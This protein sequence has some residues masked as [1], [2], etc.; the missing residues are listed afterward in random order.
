MKGRKVLFLFLA[1]SSYAHAYVPEVSMKI[2]ERQISLSEQ[3][4][5]QLINEGKNLYSKAIDIILSDHYWG[6]YGEFTGVA[7]ET[8]G[9]LAYGMALK[10]SSDLD[11][12]FVYKYNGG[13]SQKNINAF[14]L[15]QEALEAIKSVFGTRYTY[16]MKQPVINIK[17]K[18][19]DIDIAFF[20]E[21]KNSTALCSTTKR[22]SEMNVGVDNTTATWNLSEKMSL[23]RRFDEVFSKNSYKREMI[24]RV[25]KLLKEWRAIQ[26]SDAEVKVPSVALISGLYAYIDH[27]N[28]SAETKYLN[29]INLL[30]DTVQYILYNNFNNSNC[31]DT[32]NIVMTLP[33]YQTNQNLL[34]KMPAASKKELCKKMVE[35]GSVLQVASSINTPP[36]DAVEMLKPYLGPIPY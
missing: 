20:N 19:V 9:S 27:L 5:Q 32:E 6:K 31:E 15:K 14:T 23:Y 13:A 35:F 7:E 36:K 4:Q 24:N 22:C 26:F 25:G 34:D 8:Q 33:V 12:G 2:Y 3:Q 29:S 11:I 16:T 21:L 30:S 28:T 17:G 1:I 10:D 18:C